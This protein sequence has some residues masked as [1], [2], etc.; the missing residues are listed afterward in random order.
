MLNESER[1][2]GPTCRLLMTAHIQEKD[3]NALK[4]LD[5]LLEKNVDYKRMLGK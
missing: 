2:N 4:R 3:A 1:I 5:K